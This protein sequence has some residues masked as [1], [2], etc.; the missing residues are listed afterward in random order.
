MGRFSRDILRSWDIES[1]YVKGEDFLLVVDWKVLGYS[2][3]LFHRIYLDDRLQYK[4]RYW[5]RYKSV[6]I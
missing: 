1:T 4:E 2:V 3:S 6:L 5:P